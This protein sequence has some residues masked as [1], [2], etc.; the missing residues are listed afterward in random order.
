MT[1]ASQ[2]VVTTPAPQAL[3]R[4]TARPASERVAKVAQYTILI[5]LGLTWIFPLYWMVSSA[6]KDDPQVYT[7]PPRLIPNPAYWNNFH[8]AWTRLDFNAAAFNSVFR[9]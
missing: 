4:P 3:P 7:V 1:T 2:T 6:L 5:L 9:Y 8:D